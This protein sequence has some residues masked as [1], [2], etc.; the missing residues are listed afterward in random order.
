MPLTNHFERVRK[1]DGSLVAYDQG[2]IERAIARALA[3]SRAGDGERARKLGLKVSAIARDR[4]PRRYPAVEQIQDIVEEVLI[5]EGYAQAAKKFILYRQQRAELR[6]TKKLL[7]VEDELKLSVNAVRVLE[8]RYL[9][10][11]E[12]GRIRETPMQMLR[13]VAAAVARAELNCGSP[14][15]IEASPR[16]SVLCEGL[17]QAWLQKGGS[18]RGS[19]PG[20]HPFPGVAK[21]GELR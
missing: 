14:C 20:P 18:G 13:R 8:R 19:T 17:R 1:R 10:R 21:R 9:R 4:L 5:A 3:A 15:G 11:D 2:R 6:E 16:Q 12:E 7:G